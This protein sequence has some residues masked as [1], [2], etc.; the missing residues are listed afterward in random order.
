MLLPNHMTC[1][2]LYILE[3]QQD[4]V[5]VD[6]SQRLDDIVRKHKVLKGM[7]LWNVMKHLG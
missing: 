6:V 4:R 5:V 1:A 2:K 7:C 3:S